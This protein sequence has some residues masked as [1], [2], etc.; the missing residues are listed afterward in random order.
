MSTFDAFL[1][2]C[3]SDCVNA[4]VEVT[5]P[6]CGGTGTVAVHVCRSARECA[7]RCLQV[8]ACAACLG[9]GVRS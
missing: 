4:R 7:R 2:Q 6:D 8:Q 1:A 9:L 5:C 3:A